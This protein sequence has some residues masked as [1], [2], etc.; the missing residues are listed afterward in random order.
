MV[1]VIMVVE[2]TMVAIRS[3]LVHPAYL[4]EMERMGNQDCP[5]FLEIVEIMDLL[6]FQDQPAVQEMVVHPGHKDPSDLRDHKAFQAF[7]VSRVQSVLRAP[8]VLQVKMEPLEPL[9]LME[10][11]V[12]MERLALTDQRGRPEHLDGMVPMVQ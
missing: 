2:I 10:R 11:L 9:A 8:S 1:K 7:R 4:D 3:F 5:E 12:K 6:V